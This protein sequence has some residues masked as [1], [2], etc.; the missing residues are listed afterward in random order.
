ME[1]QELS[2]ILSS[3]QLGKVFRNHI[4]QHLAKRQPNSLPLFITQQDGFSLPVLVISYGILNRDS[5]LHRFSMQPRIDYQLEAYEPTWFLEE[6]TF[7]HGQHFSC[8]QSVTRLSVN[9]GS[10]R[11]QD[12]HFHKTRT[13]PLAAR[14]RFQNPAAQLSGSIIDNHHQHPIHS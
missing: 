2:S 4:A 3:F 11:I 5:T 10:V 13:F 6:T 14:A 7:F 8:I 1:V 12:P 9:E